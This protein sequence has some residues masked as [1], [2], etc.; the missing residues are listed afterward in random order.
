MTT[1]REALR[2]FLKS[3]GLTIQEFADRSGVSR[4]AISLLLSD[5]D[6]EP[7]LSLAFKIERVTGGRVP[8]SGWTNPPPRG[9]RRPAHQP[10]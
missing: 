6:R 10:A 7:S 2:R 9:A 3:E 1:S 4:P 5:E 8:A